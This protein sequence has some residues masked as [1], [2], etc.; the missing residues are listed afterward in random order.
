MIFEPR[1]TPRDY[2]TCSRS[3]MTIQSG[4]SNLAAYEVS[5]S[6]MIMIRLPAI[7]RCGRNRVCLRFQRYRGF[8]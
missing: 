3:G 1:F 7:R 2:L 6:S 8:P 4:H 5:A